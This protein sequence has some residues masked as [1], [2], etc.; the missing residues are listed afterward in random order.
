MWK[1]TYRLVLFLLLYCGM[2]LAQDGNIDILQS[3]TF[4][5]AL[6]QLVVTDANHGYVLTKS[7][8]WESQG[9]LM[10]WAVKSSLPV[11]Y[12][13]DNPDEQLDYLKNR[14]AFWGDTVVV[15]GNRGTVLYSNDAGTS[16]RDLSDTTYYDISMEWV[17]GPNSKNIWISGGVSKKGYLFKLNIEDDAVPTLERMDLEIMDYRLS[18]IFFTD[19]QHGFAAAG[20]TKGDIYRTEDGGQSWDVIRGN[21]KFNSSGRIYD[22]YFVNSDTGYAVGYYGNL[23]KTTD[24]SRSLWTA[25]HTPEVDAKDNSYLNSLYV[26]SANEIWF[27]GTDG[28]FY[29]STDGAATFE[30]YHAP[31]GA[32]INSMWFNTAGSGF[33]TSIYAFIQTT[34]VNNDWKLDND[35]LG[36]TWQNVTAFNENQVIMVGN[37]GILAYGDKGGFTMPNVAS[38]TIPNDFYA[39]SIGDEFA[40]ILGNKILLRGDLNFDNWE[41]V[42]SDADDFSKI[43]YD[44]TFVTPNTGFFVDNGG[45]IWQTVNAGQ[46]WENL[47]QVG[48]KLVKLAFISSLHGIALEESAG[49]IWRTLDGGSTWAA[50]TIAVKGD[51]TFHAL[52]FVHDSTLIIAGKNNI[53]ENAVIL[54]STNFGKTWHEPLISEAVAELNCVCM[55]KWLGIAAG[56]ASTILVSKD[57][58]DTWSLP[59]SSVTNGWSTEM[60]QRYDFKDATFTR[61]GDIYIVGTM[62]IVMYAHTTTDVAQFDFQDLHAQDYKLCQNYPNPFNPATTIQYS[63]PQAGDIELSVYNA[64]GQCVETL[65]SGKQ[66][67]GT[68]H[69]EWNAQQLASGLYFYYLKT[70]ERTLIKKM[71]LIR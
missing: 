56:R 21:F 32:T 7:S 45:N 61:N 14:F 41:P 34:P 53:T 66:F 12:Q 43:G 47:G 15:V 2:A 3:F 6:V 35:W 1:R 5:D 55:N 68:Y 26:V 51:Y 19:S 44:L 9:N 20:G 17:Q 70:P 39:A 10:S 23:F 25:V 49:F 37:D 30:Q 59:E 28:R 48:S 50:D 69:V 13:K 58:G 40:Y 16:W 63:I 36:T 18:Q 31:V 60:R 65:V 4:D 71:V 8:L 52:D 27:S 64:L 67:A 11:R 62:G 24:G 46:N 42:L 33:L 57:Y 38:T 29:H 54:K 22:W